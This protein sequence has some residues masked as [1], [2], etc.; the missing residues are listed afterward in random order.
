MKAED[1]II[2]IAIMKQVYQMENGLSTMH[3]LH[4]ILCT[5]MHCFMMGICS[6]KC[7]VR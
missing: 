2:I 3:S 7:I 5:V 1:T 6:E 4:G